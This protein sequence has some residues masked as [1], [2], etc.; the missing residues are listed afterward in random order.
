[1]FGSMADHDLPLGGQ[2]TLFREFCELPCGRWGENCFDFVWA[3]R[4]GLWPIECFA[5]NQENRT[6][7]L[8]AK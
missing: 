4:A 2:K 6:Q 7:D 5:E 1:M 3:A 8:K